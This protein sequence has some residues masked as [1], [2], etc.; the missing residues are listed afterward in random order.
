MAIPSLN[1]KGSVRSLGG[2]FTPLSAKRLIDSQFKGLPPAARAYMAE[3]LGNGRMIH[4]TDFN[5]IITEA[6]KK[7]YISGA[8]AEQ[9]KDAAKLPDKGKYEGVDFNDHWK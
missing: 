5:E 3:K 6:H 9:M 2:K 8:H 7:G 1:F 4:A